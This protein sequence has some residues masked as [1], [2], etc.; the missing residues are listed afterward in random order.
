[1]T[2]PSEVPG[3]CVEVQRLIRM[4]QAR[5]GTISGTPEITVEEMSRQFGDLMSANFG[6]IDPYMNQVLDAWEHLTPTP[7][8]PA[9]VQFVSPCPPGAIYGKT[10]WLPGSFGCDLFLPRGTP[11]YAPAD[12]VVE[13]LIG[14]QGISGG[15][16]MILSLADH[17][18]AW[19]YRH[20][21]GVS[22]LRVGSRPTQGQQVGI[23]M[24]TS[25]DQLGNVP[26]WAV[27]A[28]GRPFP[29]KYQHLDLSVDK[30]TNQFAPTGGG[31]G[32][33]DADVWMLGMVKYQGILIERTPGPTDAGIGI[34]AAIQM[35]GRPE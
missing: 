8:P 19:R 10:K 14:G 31:G 17:S 5:W 18:W 12:C 34:G 26:A 25:L 29:D 20:V 23:V 15:A 11:I 4:G 35:M 32:N 3:I 9:P 13:E 33:Q 24:D 2:L 27:Q 16:E 6:P 22:G 1:M 7:P 28:A 30:G 21:Q